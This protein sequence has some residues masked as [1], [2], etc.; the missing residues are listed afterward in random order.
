MNNQPIGIFDSGVGGLSTLRELKALL[1]NENYVFVA[2]Q[3]NFPYGGKTKEQLQN[4]ADKITN[5]LINKKKVKVI[6]IACNTSTV[7][8]LDFLRSKYKIPI[9]GT[10]PVIKTIA[11]L[12][13]TGKTAVLSTPA[14][15]KSKYLSDLIKKFAGDITVHKIGETGLEDLVEKGD[16][17]SSK[18]DTI[19]RKSLVPLK[20]MEVDAI[21]LSC[22]HYPFLRDQVKLIM[23]S[24]VAVV[25]SVGAVARRTKE[26]LIKENLLGKLCLEDLYYTTGDEIKFK[27]AIKN[28]LDL[29]TENVYNLSL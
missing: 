19:L 29:K 7:Y 15:A 1:P 5:F 17:K 21:A 13:K 28:L 24:K 12:T 3:K 16:F 23:G 9:I 25:D 18:I 2:D 4:Y 8:S 27:K 22:T 11:K 10:V 20:K 6:V 26:I 14:T